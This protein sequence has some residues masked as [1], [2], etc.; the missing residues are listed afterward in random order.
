M[1]SLLLA[2]ALFGSV[3]IDGGFAFSKRAQST[4]ARGFLTPGDAKHLPH[5]LAVLQQPETD[6]AEFLAQREAQPRQTVSGPCAR[7]EARESCIKQVAPY[8]YRCDWNMRE[9]T[10]V[11]YRM[12]KAELRHSPTCEQW[13]TQQECGAQEVPGTLA[14]R[15]QNTTSSCIVVEMCQE[16]QIDNLF[17]Q[18]GQK[19]DQF[20]GNLWAN[21]FLATIECAFR[22]GHGC[23]VGYG[24]HCVFAVFFCTFCCCCLC[25][26]CGGPE[27]VALACKDAFKYCE[28]KLDEVKRECHERQSQSYEAEP[29]DEIFNDQSTDDWVEFGSFVVEKRMEGLLLKCRWK[30]Q[31]IGE[32]KGRIRACVVHEGARSG[33]VDVFGVCMRGV[34]EPSR[35]FTRANG[36]AIIQNAQEGDTILFEYTVGGGGG[37]VLHIKYFEAL[38]NYGDGYTGVEDA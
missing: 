12:S 37:H 6:C 18:P 9:K 22:L 14:C 35:T 31:G 19:H 28:A 33:P 3:C 16:W 2:L 1:H 20:I 11:D 30:D 13:E 27:V 7:H 24:I 10:C 29:D 32:L 17:H 21:S 34:P 25:E 4:S 26:P 8:G 5:F 23:G 36:D 15:W 38:P